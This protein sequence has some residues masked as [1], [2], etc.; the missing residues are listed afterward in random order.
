MKNKQYYRG[1]VEK[2][3]NAETSGAEEIILRSFL[4]RTEDA[5]F[6]DVKAVMGYTVLRKRM[7]TSR[8]RVDMRWVRY[9]AV[10]CFAI[11]AAFLMIPSK[12][13]DKCYS[14]NSGARVSDARI[15][16]NTV[17]EQF[18]QFFAASEIESYEMNKD[19]E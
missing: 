11:A 13:F 3:F 16:M 6:D 4:A 19:E 10:C 18:S 15:V 17:D 1:L 7:G 5:A 8:A 9:A 14:D 2:Y 12:I